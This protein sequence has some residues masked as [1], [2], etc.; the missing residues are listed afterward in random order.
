VIR[1]AWD[2]GFKRIYKKK[3]KYNEEVLL[4]DIGTHDEVY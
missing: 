3:V 2:H 1:I 4:T